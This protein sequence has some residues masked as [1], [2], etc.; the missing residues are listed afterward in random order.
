MRLVIFCP[1]RTNFDLRSGS[2]VRIRGYTEYL[3]KNCI[4]TL[5]IAPVRPFYVPASKF[6]CF[7]LQ[8]RFKKLFLLHNIAFNYFLFRPLSYVLMKLLS[9]YAPV[10]SLLK[11]LQNNSILIS[12]QDNS[13]ALFLKLRYDIDTVYDIHGILKIQ[14]EYLEGMNFWKRI[15]FLI[16]VINEKQAYLRFKYVNSI[17][18]EMTFYIRKELNYDGQAFIAPDGFLKTSNSHSNPHAELKAYRKNLML[19]DSDNIILFFGSFK[20]IGGVHLLAEVFCDMAKDYHNLKLILIG[21]GQMKNQIIGRIEKKRLSHRVI[22]LKEIPYEELHTFLQIANVL[23]IPDLD[24]HYNRLIPH[25]KTYD[26]ILSGKPILISDFEVNRNL[27][28]EIKYPSTFFKPSDTSDLKLKL[29]YLLE[30]APSEININD[31][32]YQKFAYNYHAGSLIHQYKR[33]YLLK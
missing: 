4:N 25:I 24:N 28:N 1:F 26:A 10:R 13:I 22:F 30:K 8:N 17:N 20:K 29:K 14:K 6:S 27:M 5:F 21:D 33:S 31:F 15:W 23:V 9:G 16:S 11:I 32:Q 3:I 2:N 12:H 7:P 19:N 18:N